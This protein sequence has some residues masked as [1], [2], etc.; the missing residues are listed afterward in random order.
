MLSVLIEPPQE[1]PNRAA[2]LLIAIEDHR[3]VVLLCHDTDFSIIVNA[4]QEGKGGGHLCNDTMTIRSG[5]STEPMLVRNAKFV[6]SARRSG[7]LGL[8]PPRCHPR[9]RPSMPPSSTITAISTKPMRKL[10]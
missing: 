2:A 1:L 7:L 4:C 9:I 8:P 10:D 3:P 6:G 5:L